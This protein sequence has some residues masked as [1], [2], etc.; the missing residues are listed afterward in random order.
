MCDIL[1][2]SCCSNTACK[3]E[4]V[5]VTPLQ[6]VNEQGR[7]LVCADKISRLTVDYTQTTEIDGNL[8]NPDIVWII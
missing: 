5:A 2:S 6:W 1:F 4:W 3:N 7:P 8:P